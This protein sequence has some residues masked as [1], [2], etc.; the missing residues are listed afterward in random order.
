M[1]SLIKYS[2]KN[3]YADGLRLVG[4]ICYDLEPM[5]KK[6]LFAQFLMQEIEKLENKLKSEYQKDKSHGHNRNGKYSVE[7]DIDVKKMKEKFRVFLSESEVYLTFQQLTLF[8][9]I[10]E[11]AQE[12]A[13]KEKERM[14]QNNYN[15]YDESSREN[16][17]SEKKEIYRSE[18]LNDMAENNP[19]LLEALRSKT[20]LILK[21]PNLDNQQKNEIKQSIVPGY[22]INL[23][24][25]TQINKPKNEIQ[26]NINR[27][28]YSID[29]KED[30]KEEQKDNINE[31]LNIAK[32]Q[33]KIKKIDV[34]K[35]KK[36]SE[37]LIIDNDDLNEIR[38]N[39]TTIIKPKN[40]KIESNKKKNT[41]I[42]R[43]KLNLNLNKDKDNQSIMLPKTNEIEDKK[44]DKKEGP[45]T[46]VKYSKKNV[47]DKKNNINNQK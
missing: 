36:L 15:S 30:E 18:R 8:L 17:K 19:K 7:K 24:L 47:N 14:Q 10:L 25:N 12:I 9:N 20:Q 29:D 45:K 33:E 13:E 6:G 42:K 3:K 16:K 5:D 23:N 39:K 4:E 38:D 37:S 34:K 41:T 21:R 32:E 40:N 31:N 26:N 22:H 35:G 28:N 43:K 1:E 2:D 46:E 44:E 27:I 11:D